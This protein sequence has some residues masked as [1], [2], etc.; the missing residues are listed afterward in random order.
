MLL[1]VASAIVAAGPPALTDGSAGQAPGRGGPPAGAT[2]AS[3]AA[4][5]IVI[6][7]SSG[8]DVIGCIPCDGKFRVLVPGQAGVLVSGGPGDPAQSQVAA[9]LL[10]GGTLRNLT[11][12]AS[13]SDG[14]IWAFSFWLNGQWSVPVCKI[15]GRAN[16]GQLT[17]Q[18]TVST[19]TVKSGDR[20]VLSV[21]N[22]GDPIT[23]GRFTVEWSVELVLAG[24]TGTTTGEPPTV[25]SNGQPSAHPPLPSTWVTENGK[26]TGTSA[27]DTIG[28]AVCDGQSRY[29]GALHSGVALGTGPGN[30]GEAGVAGTLPTGVLQG[31]QVQLSDADAGAWT[32]TVWVNGAPG[33]P[34]LAC[35]I[36]GSA[37]P[38][39]QGCRDDAGWVEVNEGD[40]VSLAITNAGTPSTPGAFSLN[41]F[42]QFA[43]GTPGSG[44]AVNPDDF[45]NPPPMGF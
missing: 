30:T 34:G 43:A 14:G 42:A 25:Q 20:L 18:D 39:Q 5:V 6:R 4:D 23:Q 13:A 33:A 36:D 12:R 45:T 41:W 28:C 22:P 7:G 26:V 10:N 9:T 11:V 8:S 27:P 21:G 38:G 1:G 15:D 37:D 44:P 40:R 24:S 35:T 16:P 19:A 17:C 2:G 29:V 31:L 3:A 32:F